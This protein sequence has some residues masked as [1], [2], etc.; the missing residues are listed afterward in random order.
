MKI[1]ELRD[2]I[3][4]HSREQLEYLAA[5]FYKLIP[6]DKKVD[7]DIDS[8]VMHPP[9]K[10]G[11]KGKTKIVKKKNAR[12]I[13][14]IAKEVEYF[15]SNAYA[16]NYLVPNQSISK[17]D[18]P[19]WRFVVKRLYKEILAAQDAGNDPVSCLNELVKLYEVLTYSCK[20]HLFRTYDSFE[21]A[22]IDQSEFFLRI[23]TLYRNHRDI[24]DFVHD[25]IRLIIDNP[26]NRYTLFSE[27]ID[28]F[29]EQC[30]TADLINLCF[31]R[32]ETIRNDVLQ[33]PDQESGFFSLS[34][35]MYDGMS[36]EKKEKINNLTEIGFKAKIKMYEYDNAIAYFNEHHIESTPEVKLYILVSLL[37]QYGLKGHIVNEIEKNRA[38]QPRKG[39]LDLVKYIKK[40]D[41][42]PEYI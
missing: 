33:E 15:C 41:D 21:S 11:K 29:I 5:E 9:K 35:K 32:V 19:K 42:L 24:K 36:Y 30:N 22:G 38:I 6:K 18:R 39:L 4:A 25:T 3:K 40:N 37:F 27:L 34:S 31:Q 12:D 23:L 13:Q 10:D 14:D 8:L 16:Q 1:G 7:Y 20:W 28:Y 2:V 26:L 17:K